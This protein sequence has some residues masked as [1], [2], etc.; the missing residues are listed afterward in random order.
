MKVGIY[1]ESQHVTG[2]SGSGKLHVPHKHAE[3]ISIN[4]STSPR[5]ASEQ[6]LRWENKQCLPPVP[7]LGQETVREPVTAVL[8]G[9]G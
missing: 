5:M 9:E 3:R 6:G 2:H 1:A 7:V 4:K 8:S